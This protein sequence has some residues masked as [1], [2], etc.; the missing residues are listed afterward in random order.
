MQFIFQNTMPD[1]ITT[2]K[3]PN[4]WNNLILHLHPK[5]VPEK[6]LKFTL[7]FGLG[8]MSALLFVL[9]ALTGMLLRFVYVPTPEAAYD[10]ILQIKNEVLF[11]NLIRNIHHW[12]ATLLVLINF[13][14]MLRVLFTGAYT[15]KRA[16]NW[17][18]GVIMLLLIF[19]SSFSGY[20]LPWDQLSYWAVTV[21][22]GM[23]LYIPFVG[24]FINQA[25][26]QG[27]EVGAPTLLLFYTMHTGILPLAMVILMS[28]HFWKVRKAGGVVI[29][30]NEEGEKVKK[31]PV[32]PNL[33]VKEFVVAVCLIAVILLL[34]TLF[35]APFG[36]PADP[37]ITPNPTK[38]P[39]YFMGF[40]ELILH[41]HPFVAVVLLPI[42]ILTLLFYLPKIKN[43]NPAEG[44][45][46]LSPL[47]IK[48]AK[49]ASIAA[50][51]LST[52]YILLN[53]YVLI[54]IPVFKYGFLSL[55]IFIAFTYF[56][57]RWIRKRYKANK[58]EVIQTISVFL[59][60]SF[61]IFTL[62]GILFRGE[63]MQLTF[64]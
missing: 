47:G 63:G 34:S 62:T 50:F 16:S 31:V 23:L 19:F 18:I 15:G 39:W 7:T 53:E 40:Q 6:A 11:G 32:V 46:F 58:A 8:G 13:L 42:A 2:P 57:S 41:F 35:N 45:W 10:S 27:T 12:S 60:V 5:L 22:T 30:A 28:F 54:L 14:H 48:L 9:L 26:L 24:E 33:V 3:K 17:T 64:F 43:I 1:T 52:S 20:L 59:I 56:M 38:A 25:I 29:P 55:F 51:V 21:V 37:S 4:K 36:K 61:I 49:F 44:V